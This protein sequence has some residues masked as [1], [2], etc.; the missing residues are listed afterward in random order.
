M[1]TY[2][3]LSKLWIKLYLSE[4]Y[5]IYHFIYL[6]FLSYRDVKIND[7][8]KQLI[9]DK[10]NFMKPEKVKSRWR[11]NSEMEVNESNAD[12]SVK[13]TEN[14]ISEAKAESLPKFEIIEENIYLFEK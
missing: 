13:S 5:P 12:M 11:R 2:K 4:K 10:E 14:C 1:F 3:N 6:I 9:P 7:A 8:V